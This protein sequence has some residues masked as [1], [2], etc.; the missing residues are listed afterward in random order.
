MKTQLRMLALIAISMVGLWS[1]A[2]AWEP[3][4]QS[5]SIGWHVDCG[6]IL[7]LDA[8]GGTSSFRSSSQN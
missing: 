6:R 4:V 3:A 1:K 8:K 5:A 7:M 2:G